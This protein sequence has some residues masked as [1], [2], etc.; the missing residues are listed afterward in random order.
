MV[1]HPSL[2]PPLLFCLG[3]TDYDERMYQIKSIIHVLP[4]ENYTVLEYLMRH[5]HRISL[6]SDINKMETSNLALIFSVGLLRTPQDD[7]T[8]I[9]HTDLQSKTVEAIIQQVDWFFEVDDN[10]DSGDVE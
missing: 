6:H 1:V 2:T 5:L 8:S 7:M 4:K 9:M 10:E 3:I